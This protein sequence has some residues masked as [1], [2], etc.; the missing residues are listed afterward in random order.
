MLKNLSLKNKLAISASAAII[1][2]GVLVEALSFKASLDR[3]DTEV[4]QRLESTTASYN[5]Y[6]TDWI[7]S[8]ERALTSLPT[9]AKNDAIVTHLKQIRD[10]AKFD[11]VFLAYPDGSQANANGVI[12]PPGNDDPRKWGWYTNAVATPSKVFMDNPTIAAATGANVVSLGKALSLHGQQVVLGA[13]VE[14]TDIL[15]SMEKVIIPGSGFMFI[16]NDKGNIFTHPNTKLLNKS[17]STLG[18]D[19]STIQKATNSHSNISIEI[20]G[21][22]YIMYAQ[23]IE[24]TSLITI[25]VIN[26]DSLVAPLFDAVSGQVLVT[27]IVVIICTLLFNLLCSILF[28]P[29]NNVSQALAQIANGSGDL[30]QR[31][32]V[33]N[34]DEVG[35]LANNFNTF[36]ESLQQL[37]QHIRLQSQQLTEGSE[38]STNRVNNSVKELNLQQ[39]EITMVATAVTEMAS[40]TREIA[41]HAEQTAEAAQNSSSST[42][43]GHSLVIETKASINNLANEVNE[44]SMVISELQQHSQEINTVLATIQGIAEQTNL[45]ALN[46]AIEAARAGEQGRGFAVV[47]DEVRVLSQRTHTSTEEI[48]STIDIL[49]QTTSRA[50]NLMKSSSD[51]A[52]SSVED[53]D[54]ATLALEEISSSVTLISDMATQ[55]ATAAEEQTHVTGEITQNVTSIKDVTDLLVIDSTDSLTQSHSLKE[56]AVNL[57]EKVATFKLS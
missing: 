34:K 46:A 1:L 13:D 17:V 55:I 31:I 2:G 12:L 47:A 49:Q 24:D 5:Q 11:N 36:V 48:K 10:S 4:E 32:H 45:L 20:D 53:A 41:S 56:Q 6:V 52:N 25:S 35:E 14:I 8:K 18:L 38:Q 26:Y 7:L 43:K 40:A 19:F 22:E 39:Q 9:E 29:L 3:L 44:A 30:T 37:I 21:D 57:S 23:K 27:A 42:Q 28:R 16:A 15:N 50:V 54:R 33:E 51:L